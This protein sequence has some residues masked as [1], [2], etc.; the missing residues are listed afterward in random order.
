MEEVLWRDG[1]RCVAGVDEVGRGPL[2][3]PVVA[4][5]VVLSREE[6]SWLWKLR[7]SK[8]LTPRR[9]EYLA[10]CIRGGAVVGIGVVP[11]EEIDKHGILPSTKLAMSSAIRD[12]SS[13]PDY[14]LVDGLTIPDV[15]L[16]ARAIVKGDSLS[17]S[18]AAASIVAKVHRD[19]IMVGYEEDYPG[20]GFSRNKG[21]ATA[22]HVATLHRLGYCPIHRTTF[23]PVNHCLSQST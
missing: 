5:A 15:N 20:Y 18:I 9:R 23:A 19:R 1:Y 3:G 6:K 12:L 21:Y 10:S 8:A 4:A 14:L 7:D 16:P 11:P 22:E 17:L 13:V 2:A